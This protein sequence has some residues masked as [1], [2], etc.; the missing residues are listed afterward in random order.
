MEKIQL[1]AGKRTV[2]GR[3]V[4]KLRAQGQVPAN[5]YGK[6]IKS[7]AV[8][9]AIKD[10][11]S[12]FAK[13]GATGLIEL[14]LGSETRPVLIHKVQYHPTSNEPLHVDFY[15]VNLKEKVTAKVPLI[16]TGE[17][18]AVKDKVG[19]LLHTL[20]VVEVEALPTDLPDKIEV[21]VSGLKVLQDHIKVGDLKVNTGVSILSDKEL[22][23]VTVA[24]LV[25]KEA[26]KLAKEEAEAAAA[27]AAA[28]AAEAPEAAAK[29]EAPGTPAAAAAPAAKPEE[30]K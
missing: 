5:I 9:L 1:K 28:S 20:S 15:Q 18:P 17:A 12:V 13:A 25:S 7:E 21:D 3:K 29:T 8:E 27:A 23:V 10:F 30:K 6:H 4:K 16:L 2:T 19:V 22:E 26:E 24:P 11:T 14:S